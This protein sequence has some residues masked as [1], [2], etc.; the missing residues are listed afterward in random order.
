MISEG[1]A[2]RVGVHYLAEAVDPIRYLAELR[3]AG[4]ETIESEAQ[5]TQR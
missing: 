3:E 5:V 4:V 1:N 2:V